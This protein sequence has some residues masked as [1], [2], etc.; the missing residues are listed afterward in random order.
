MSPARITESLSAESVQKHVSSSLEK[1]YTSLSCI[2][3]KIHSNPELRYQEH[4]AHDNICSLVE[5]LGYTPRRHAYGLNTSFEVESGDGGKLVVFNAEYDALPGIGHACGHNLI[6]TSSIAAFLFAAELL[7]VSSIPGRVRLL[8][9]PAEESGGGKIKLITAGAYVGVDAC[10]MAHPGPSEMKGMGAKGFVD[11][12]SATTSLA[13]K[14]V[15]VT[16]RGQNAHAGLAPWN[17]RNAL[18]A[19]VA[20]YVNISLLRQQIPPTARIHGVVRQGGAEPNIIPDSATLEYFIRDTSAASVNDLANRVEKC[21]QAGALATECTVECVWNEEADYKDLR[22]NMTIAEVFT[23]RMAT[24]GKQYLCDG[25]AHG[26]GASTDMG[27]VCYEVP[28]FHCGFSVGSEV[29]G[30]SPHDPKFALAAGTKSALDNALQC[31]MGMAMTAYD[32]L[33]DKT[34]QL[35]IREEHIE[36]FGG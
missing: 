21:F 15:A 10:L 22:P 33:T 6:A 34:V 23:R 12:V 36:N 19:V 7:K 2:N 11:G 26:M 27:N 20:S 9:T 31:A 16:F 1:H 29:K 32:I 24:L 25:R 35:Q 28:G 13:R 4:Q 5:D 17:G 3:S 14:Q 8:G 30:A 18:D